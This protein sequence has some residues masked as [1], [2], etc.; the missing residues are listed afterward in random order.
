MVC[1]N[2]NTGELV[3]E[4]NYPEDRVLHGQWSSPSMGIV[5]GQAQIY[6][7]AGD[8]WLYGNHL[9]V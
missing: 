1:I 6:F 5:N 4:Q 7:P 8:G 2:K 3:W 9:E